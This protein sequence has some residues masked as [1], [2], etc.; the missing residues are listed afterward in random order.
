MTDLTMTRLHEVMVVIYAIS[1]VFYFIDYLRKN[2]K[3]YRFAFWGVSIVWIMQSLFLV[4]YIVQTHRFPILTIFEGIYFYA[5]LLIAISIAMHCIFKL[6]LPVILMNIIAFCLIVIHTFAPAQIDATP[7][8]D[9]LISELLMFH[10]VF[11]IL[12]YGGFAIVFVFA[13]LYIFL[14]SL[15]KRKKWQPNQFARLPSLSQTEQ[16]MIY[17]LYAGVPL[18]GISLIL[19]IMWAYVA[20]G[21]F[22][23]ADVK[24]IGSL[25]SMF[26]YSYII[27]K[28]RKGKLYGTKFAWA[29]IYAF[30]I[31]LIN[32][33][34]GSRFSAFHFWY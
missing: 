30:L 7:L 13:M 1:L 11:A 19:G 12:S 4:L 34:L 22:P 10:V 17:A 2:Q 14:Y 5:W 6:D 33:F 18:L 28:N 27:Y 20:L 3:L 25:I 29:T 23:L 9:N 32:F 8:G 26:I 16:G 31:V 24:I 21:S 15:L